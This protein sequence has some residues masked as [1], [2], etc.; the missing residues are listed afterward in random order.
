MNPARFFTHFFKKKTVID[1]PGSKQ[2]KQTYHKS[3]YKFDSIR[4][5]DRAEM[6][7]SNNFLLYDTLLRIFWLNFQLKFSISEYSVRRC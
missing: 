3:T 1:T 4:C 2:T 5:C 6:M 7:V